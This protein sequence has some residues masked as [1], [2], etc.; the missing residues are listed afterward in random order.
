MKKLLAN[1]HF[2]LGSL[3]T[4]GG[5]VGLV[6]SF[7]LSVEKLNSLKD[8]Y[9]LA[10]CNFNPLIN[11]SYALNPEFSEL[12][13]I[14]H[15]FIGIA[16]FAGIVTIGMLLM[17]GTTLERRFRLGLQA[18]VT[19][20]LV[21]AHWLIYQSLYVINTLC[22]FCMAVWVVAIAI[23]WYVS[24]YNLELV[25]IPRSGRLA[26]AVAVIRNNHA[27][28]LLVW[29]LVIFFLI[30]YRFWYYWSTLIR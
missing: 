6:A 20:G 11:C 25:K 30:L 28:V 26:Q 8:P 3:L 27:A 16:A 19:I 24:L 23:F 14:P 15:S 1:K 10:G 13:G 2:L 22:P 18:G 5:T 7:V 17:M 21:A 9:Y 29:Y 12:F 4:A